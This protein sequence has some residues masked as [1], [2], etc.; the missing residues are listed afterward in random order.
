MSRQTIARPATLEGAGLHLG[1]PCRLTFRPAPSGHGI[2]LVR[3]DV[4][5]AKPIAATVANVSETER[6]TQLGKG[7][8]TVHTVEHVLA[9]VV[10]AGI[11]DLLIEMD[12]PE[13]PILDGSARPFLSALDDAGLAAHDGAP[14]VL[15]LTEPVR[16]IDGE[17]VYEAFPSDRL[18]LDVTIE[19]AHPLIGRQSRK[20]CV[21]K[22]TF[23]SELASARTFGFTREVEWLRSR[24]LIQGAS[25]DNAIVL[26]ESEIVSGPLRW[27]DEF[28]RHKAMDCIGDLALAGAR[29]QARIVALKPSHRGTVTLVREIM[30]SGLLRT[31]NGIPTMTT[32]SEGGKGFVYGIEDIMRVLPHRYPFLLVDRIIEIEEGKRV[33]GVKNVTI[34]EPFFQG[35]FPGHPIMPGVLIV[36]AMAQVGGMLLLGGL[37]EPDTKVVYFMSLDN[38]KFRKPVK[39]G[40]QIVFEVEIVQIRGKVCKTRGV[41]RVDGE[42]VAEA[43]MAAMVRDK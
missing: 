19:F 4:A 40:D 9:A 3:T 11:D 14:E 18:E 2:S 12:G 38:I 24:G 39:P 13:P 33:I 43:E 42:V 23:D 26:D 36:E 7:S 34:N 28:V 15:T 41:A 5:G 27:P 25:I 30:R 37:A 17:S 1:K 21:T 6:R 31:G 16:I 20:M 22:A 8:N 29:V 10:A 32:K 35:H